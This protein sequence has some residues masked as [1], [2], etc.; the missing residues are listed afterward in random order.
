MSIVS[1]L[2]SIT[3]GKM[4][5]PAIQRKY[6]WTEHQI[7]RLMDSIMLGYP[8]GTFLFWRVSKEIVNE[9]NYSMY[10]FIKNYHERD[11]FNNPPAPKPL[12][13][14][15]PGECIYAVLDG[16][17]RLTSLYIS[18]QGSFRNKIPKK[19]WNNNEA[20]PEKE[21]YIDLRHLGE[22]I[23]NEY[24]YKFAFLTEQEVSA[25][26]TKEDNKPL[27]F[28]VKE[29]LKYQ[30]ETEVNKK[31][32]KPNGWIDEA[33][34]VSDTLILLFERLVRNDLI[35]YFEIDNSNSIDDV[36]DIF[37][38]VNSGGTMLSKTDLLY[39][40]IVC[41]WDGARDEV[42]KLLS[43]INRIG[44][45][46]SFSNDFIMRTCLYLLDLNIGLKVESFKEE[47]VHIIHQR[48]D[49]IKDAIIS[50]TKLLNEFGFYAG[51]ITSYAAI[52]PIV[53]YKYQ[54]GTFD[55]NT[56]LELRKYFIMAQLRQI[57]GSSNTTAL[58]K[59]RTVLEKTPGKFNYSL[60]QDIRFHGDNTL[61]YTDM[62]IESLLDTYEIGP[63]TFMLLSLLYPNLKYEQVGFHQDHLHPYS[64][65]ETKKLTGLI[66]PDG[67]EITPEKIQEWQHLR[68]TIPNL[69]LLEGRENESKNKSPL[70][71]WMNEPKNRDCVKYLPTNVPLDL[72][73]FEEFY[74]ARKMMM[75]NQLKSI[76]V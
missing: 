9:K 54:G 76:L 56:K 19:H 12:L 37:I 68:N 29:I 41:H 7:I 62:D 42:D 26:N 64:A 57:F 45:G 51:N 3:N 30:S 10:Q 67:N 13:N 33:D 25:I 17:Q 14:S 65:F 2:D 36:L 18:L 20:Y 21:L 46:F 31:L 61:R 49:S 5:L 71:K 47:N 4:Y 73:H 58:T 52:I 38:R 24:T 11:C 48:W 59:V 66:L 69:Q 63:Y 72:C 74:T 75:C 55:T 8:I 6:I 23:D 43:F 28:K 40:T 16:Q 32:I 50:T 27:W 34:Q 35:N 70:E 60:L 53:Y 1:M 39:S 44:E 15:A 22:D